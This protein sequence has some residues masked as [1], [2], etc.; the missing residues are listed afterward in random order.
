MTI[1]TVVV[2]RCIRMETVAAHE[3]SLGR[4]KTLRIRLINLRFSQDLL[5]PLS[6]RLSVH[7]LIFRSCV[8]VSTRVTTSSCYVNPSRIVCT[9]YQT[10]KH[11]ALLLALW[12]PRYV[13]VASTT[14]AGT[15]G[16]NHFSSMTSGTTSPHGE[17]CHRHCFTSHPSNDSA[18]LAVV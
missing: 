1:E 6:Y 16:P 14:H 8:I 13:C 4:V 2:Y 12:R 10:T 15:V 17:E 5:S 3:E 11:N 18:I 7:Q 9:T